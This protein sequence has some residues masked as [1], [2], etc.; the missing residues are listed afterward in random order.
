VTCC[1]VDSEDEVAGV[2]DLEGEVIDIVVDL[3]GWATVIAVAQ[4]EYGSS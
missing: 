4:Q 2:A 3:V 1:I